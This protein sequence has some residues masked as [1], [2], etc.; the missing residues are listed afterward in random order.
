[1][2]MGWDGFMVGGCRYEQISVIKRVQPAHTTNKIPWQMLSYLTSIIPR[3]NPYRIL[4]HA[5]K[6][7]LK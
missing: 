7:K 1:M 2:K 6:S 4:F 5:S 3:S